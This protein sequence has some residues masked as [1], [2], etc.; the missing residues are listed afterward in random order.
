MQAVR[1]TDA[2]GHPSWTDVIRSWCCTRQALV[3][4]PVRAAIFC[5]KLPQELLL[6]GPPK[7]TN[8]NAVNLEARLVPLCYRAN[9]I[10]KVARLVLASTTC[11]S[12]VP[13][14]D[15]HLY[16]RA[17]MLCKVEGGEKPIQNA[18]ASFEASRQP[19]LARFRGLPWEL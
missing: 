14:V 15:N 18:A 7:H 4:A 3:D 11:P 17:R 2:R 13:E 1:Y 12:A 19:C 10:G 16:L 9:G 5:G 8:A 6:Q